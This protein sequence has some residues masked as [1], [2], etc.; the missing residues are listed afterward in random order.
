[1][2]MGGLRVEVLAFLVV[3]TC[4]PLTAEIEVQVN[5]LFPKKEISSFCFPLVICQGEKTDEIT[6]E[7][8]WFKFLL[9]ISQK[10]QFCERIYLPC[11]LLHW[12][13]QKR[14]EDECALFKDPNLSFVKEEGPSYIKL[15][16]CIRVMNLVID[17]WG[18]RF[19]ASKFFLYQKGLRFEFRHIYTTASGDITVKMQRH[20]PTKPQSKENWK[21]Q[22]VTWP[23]WQSASRNFGIHLART[24]TKTILQQEFC[25]N[26]RHVWLH[27]RFGSVI[28][29][30]TRPKIPQRT[31]VQHGLRGQLQILWME[32]QGRQ[33]A[34]FCCGNNLRGG[35]PKFTLVD[36]WHLCI[37]LP[38]A[39]TFTVR[40]FFCSFLL[41][42]SIA[43][44]GVRQG[45]SPSVG[46]VHDIPNT[47]QHH[48]RA[49]AVHQRC[50][51]Q[52]ERVF[53]VMWTTQQTQ[54]LCNMWTN[55][56]CRRNSLQCT[57]W[58]ISRFEQLTHCK[59]K[60]KQNKKKKKQISSAQVSGVWWDFPPNSSYFAATR[61]N[62][63]WTLSLNNTITKDEAVVTESD[64]NLWGRHAFLGGRPGDYS[65]WSN[66]WNSCD[67]EI[68]IVVQHWICS[69]TSF[70]HFRLHGQCFQRNHKGPSCERRAS[71]S[72]R[73]RNGGQCGS[74][75][76][77]FFR[78]STIRGRAAWRRE[79]YS[80]FQSTIPDVWV[81]ELWPFH[82]K[83][84]QLLCH[85]KQFFLC[86]F[87][88][89]T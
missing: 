84:W 36:Q 54:A 19:V 76:L 8:F 55:R 23:N 65:E 61:E 57:H 58:N 50:V 5:R 4:S 45:T 86:D 56:N 60:K 18:A 67:W 21:I 89:R 1:M 69:M 71:F 10:A 3:L 29:D 42:A 59:K 83:S 47:V 66:L 79:R 46:N 30:V 25:V 87:L 38:F 74:A 73:K 32:N 68:P 40:P 12:K 39:G 26:F 52:P 80:I 64:V 70:R 51:L 82:L 16:T 75:R 85:L 33:P 9:L 44:E 37:F 62:A 6:A 63:I 11:I 41:A 53:I 72:E 48:R 15:G 27:W 28:L 20:L 78:G 17:S 35:R 77:R 14:S 31:I 13:L 2:K 34:V 88:V 81:V 24:K 22:S 7:T 43:D 49:L